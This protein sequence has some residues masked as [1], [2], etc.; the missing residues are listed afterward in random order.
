MEITASAVKELRER[1]GA[2][3]MD[4][5]KALTTVSGDMEAA[6]DLLRTQGLAKVDKKASRVTAEGRVALAQVGDSALL[7]EL[8]C[9]TDFVAKD[10]NFVAFSNAVAQAA[11]T[12]GA[13]DIDVIRELSLGS[14]TVEAARAA[15]VAKIGENVQV[16]RAFKVEGPVVGTYLHGSRIGV[17]IAL[18]GGSVDLARGIAMHIA[19]MNPAWKDLSEIPADVQQREKDIALEQM[20]ADPK[21]ANKPLEIKEKIVAGKIRKN[22]SSQTLVGQEYA[23][24][25]ANGATVE[26]VL[27]KAGATVLRFVRVVV[28]EGIEKKTEDFAAEVMAQVAAS[29][30]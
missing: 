3:M 11:A 13:V 10:D 23:S 1:T 15:L 8:N 21:D 19:A 18:D 16:R 2:G 20:N 9:E 6:I 26:E 14:E 30:T 25:D 5:K 4:C 7:V 28:G 22:L 12:A 17:A 27:K 29:S 24:S